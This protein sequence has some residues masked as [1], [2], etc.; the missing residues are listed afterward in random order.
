MELPIAFYYYFNIESSR[1]VQTVSVPLLF[2][3]LVRDPSLRGGE[4]VILPNLGGGPGGD[5]RESA[6]MGMER[7]QPCSDADVHPSGHVITRASVEEDPPP[8]LRCVA[9]GV[10][11]IQLVQ[12]QKLFLG[13]D[14]RRVQ[15]NPGSWLSDKFPLVSP[16]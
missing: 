4:E 11:G 13:Q 9:E 12:L 14:Q 10:A 2:G 16:R 5:S 3:W 15:G 6:G 8:P 1:Y 7:N